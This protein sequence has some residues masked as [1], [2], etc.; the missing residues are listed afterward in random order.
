MTSGTSTRTTLPC[1]PQASSTRPRSRAS[2][3]APTP[4]RAP[5]PST[6]GRA[7]APGRASG[8]ARA[9][10]RS[11]HAVGQVVEPAPGA[12][13]A[14]ARA[15][16][17]RRRDLVEHGG[18]G[19]ARHGVAAERAAEAAGRNRVHR[20]RR[21]RSRPPAAGRRRAT[22]PRRA[23]RARR[24]VLDRPDAA[25]AADAA[26]HLVVDVEDPVLRADR[27]PLG[28]VVRHRDEAALALHGLEHDAGDGPGRRRA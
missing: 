21:A 15:Q 1:S 9:P 7:R 22:C 23:G 14:P 8:R 4:A 27:E 5:A 20:S 11:R 12:R 13:P 16:E 19:R 3:T 28:E 26:L 6:R 25:G 10:R 18:R 17:L 2:L 24:L